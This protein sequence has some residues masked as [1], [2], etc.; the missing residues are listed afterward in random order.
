VGRLALN[1][2]HT[3]T[4]APTI[5]PPGPAAMIAHRCAAAAVDETVGI[6]RQ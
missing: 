1:G 3:M 2:K 6:D 4:T 5:G